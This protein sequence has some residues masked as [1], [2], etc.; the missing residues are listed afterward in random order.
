MAPNTH[1][2]LFISAAGFNILAGL[3]MLVVTAKFAELMGLQLNPTATMFI[4]LTACIIL[5]FGGAYWMIARDPARFR[6][7]IPLGIILKAVVI[8][9]FFGHWLSGSIS[10]P[11]PALA[12]GDVIYA[13]LFWR[14]YKQTATRIAI[15]HST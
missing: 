3:P 13:V 8:V 5:V 11:L 14:Y 4:Q 2:I 1:R 6:P 7:Y 9:V 10:W 15:G 12:S